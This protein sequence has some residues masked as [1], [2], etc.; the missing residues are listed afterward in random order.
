MNCSPLASFFFPEDNLPDDY[1][2]PPE[3]ASF[4]DLHAA[5]NS[6]IKQKNEST[7]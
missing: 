2:D 1:L 5:L 7:I 6:V 3:G 4:E